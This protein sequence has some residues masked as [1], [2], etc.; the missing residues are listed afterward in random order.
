MALLLVEVVA[1]SRFVEERRP[2]WLLMAGTAAAGAAGVR[3]D[4]VALHLAVAATAALFV[5]TDRARRRGLGRL[6]VPVAGAVA[7]PLATWGVWTLYLRLGIGMQTVAPLASEEPWG[8][9]VIARYLGLL[10]AHTAT[11]GPVFLVWL[12][13]V[14]FTIAV[15]RR[16]GEPLFYTVAAAALL[17]GLVLIFGSLDRSF[18]GGL[19]E[20]VNSSLK[21]ALF[22]AIPVAGIAAAL[23]PPS[24]WLAGVGR[25]WLH[26]GP[27]AA[28]PR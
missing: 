17:A 5:L 2:A 28:R 13:S 21:R 8:P 27:P 24:R 25:G 20:L 14:P 22:Y 16:R 4:A 3:P 26:D 15:G 11:Y 19:S 9:V 1:W 23:A 7:A 18:A 12:V 6:A 10:M